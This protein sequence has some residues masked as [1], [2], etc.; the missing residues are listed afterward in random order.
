MTMLSLDMYVAGSSKK[1]LIIKLTFF[2]HNYKRQVNVLEENT[3]PYL[4]E[5]EV[6]C[7][8]KL[9]FP[10]T[11]EVRCTKNQGLQQQCIN[12]R[13]SNDR[14]VGVVDATELKSWKAFSGTL[15][16]SN[17]KIDELVFARD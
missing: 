15:I 7:N 6:T 9:S 12:L 11:S 10:F 13:S 4:P 8:F 2:T 1:Y 3:E 16:L 14:H 17:F 5:C